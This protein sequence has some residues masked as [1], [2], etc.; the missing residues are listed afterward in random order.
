M[1]SP[2]N[3]QPPRLSP[4]HRFLSDESHQP[5]FLSVVPPAPDTVHRWLAN[6][7]LLTGVPFE[8]LVP[9]DAMLP[10]ESLR[11]FF[12]DENWIERLIDGALS[13]VA[14]TGLDQLIADTLS[15]VLRDPVNDVHAAQVRPRLLGD[16][17]TSAEPGKLN[18]PLTGFLIRSVVASN[19]KGI[20]VENTS[21]TPSKAPLTILRLDQPA[22]GVVLGL[23]N[24]Q[25][26]SVTFKHPPE[27]LHFGVTGQE[28][29]PRTW[30]QELRIP[31]TGIPYP[32]PGI[33]VP[34][35]LRDGRSRVVDVAATAAAMKSALT[36]PP[37]TF[38]SAEFAIQMIESPQAVTFEMTYPAI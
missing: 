23:F 32:E 18:W 24:G 12:V 21:N 1:N 9:D 19:W 20:V 33:S 2:S 5:D 6:L 29:S 7:V 8:Y 16:D 37:D 26:G 22:Q 13:V 38:T 4:L 25:L 27:S 11:F 30:Q 36:P 14:R 31:D 34:V 35:V 17:V 3:P 15:T 28:H 10:P